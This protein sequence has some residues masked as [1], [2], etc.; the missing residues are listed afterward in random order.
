MEASWAAAML[1]RPMPLVV[2]V[3]IV[4]ASSVAIYRFAPGAS[5]ISRMRLLG[6][7]IGA[8][9]TCALISAASSYVPVHEAQAVWHVPPERY[10]SAL[11]NEFLVLFVLMAYV[12]ILGI[13]LI[14]APAVFLLN[15]WNRATVPWVT[16]ASIVIS[17]V[18]SVIV[19]LF[20]QPSNTTFANTVPMLVGA[21]ALLA[22]GFSIG[23]RLPWR[24]R[25]VAA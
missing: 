20:S 24:S 19:V 5:S 10:W 11:L 15:R 22:L 6:G 7:Y 18:A 21:H 2:A 1:A 23:A 9:A 3:L 17:L 14:G 12:S 4:I 8:I 13:A 16:V 25:G